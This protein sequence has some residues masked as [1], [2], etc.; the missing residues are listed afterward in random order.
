LYYIIIHY[1]DQVYDSIFHNMYHFLYT[2]AQLRITFRL[3][4]TCGSMTLQAAIK[5]C[6]ALRRLAMWRSE[7][8]EYS[9]AKPGT[10]ASLGR[11]GAV[12]EVLP[13]TVFC[14]TIR[15]NE[16]RSLKMYICSTKSS[17]GNSSFL[18][19]HYTVALEIAGGPW[20]NS[21]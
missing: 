15:R 16:F 9:P 12:Q 7:A 6:V 8:W 4:R 5:Q 3:Q 17:F 13:W 18:L 20:K 19:T 21:S 14:F 10:P 1:F 2:V 11:V